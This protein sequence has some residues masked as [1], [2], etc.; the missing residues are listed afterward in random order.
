MWVGVVCLFG[1]VAGVAPLGALSLCIAAPTLSWAAL[2]LACNALCAAPRASLPATL[3]LTLS[4]NPA[5][6]VS[7]AGVTASGKTV[8]GANTLA[9]RTSLP[10]APTVAVATPTSATQAT[11]LLTPP[12]NGQ[13]VSL[14]I[15]N[16]CLEAQPSS[17]VSGD[18]V[19]T[20]LAFTG[21]T[22]GASYL[23]SATAKIGNTLVPASNT[24]PLTMPARNAPV[25]LTAAATG[26]LTGAATA[27]SPD[28]TTFSKV[29]QGRRLCDPP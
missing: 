8:Q 27:A 1:V 3:L 21:L 25:L 7:V 9:I 16:V 6:T 19:N 5:D 24:L 10:G 13:T 2:A 26:A 4:P 22:A 29:R 17:C 23:V 15:V 11:V 28:T 20:Q 12:T 18:S 14:Y